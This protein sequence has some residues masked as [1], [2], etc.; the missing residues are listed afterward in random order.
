MDISEVDSAIDHH[1]RSNIHLDNVEMVEKDTP[2]A[3]LIDK[4]GFHAGI[5][6]V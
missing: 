1:E 5:V 3:E 6:L 2:Q 4:D